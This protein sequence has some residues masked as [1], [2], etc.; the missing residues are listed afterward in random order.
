M[1]FKSLLFH[2][3]K[4][5]V[6][7]FFWKKNVLA[8]I[9]TLL[10]GLYFLA[11][12]LS[13]GLFSKPLI[14][15]LAPD[16][17]PTR[18]FLKYLF[19]YHLLDF[20]MRFKVQEIAILNPEPYRTLP[21][22]TKRL[23]SFPMITSHFSF[24]NVLAIIIFLPFT[25]TTIWAEQ[26]ILN[27]L[28]WIVL[29]LSLVLTSNYLSVTFKLFLRKYQIWGYVLYFIVLGFVV[30]EFMHITN[31][32][33]AYAWGFLKA[34][35]YPFIIL[36]PMLGAILAFRLG[37]QF[38]IKNRYDGVSSKKN[39]KI[40][41]YSFLENY[42]N[43]GHFLMLELKFIFRNKKVKAM[44]ISSLIFIGV[45]L[46]F[47]SNYNVN[48]FKNV[49]SGI[50]IISMFPTNYSQI[51]FAGMSSH[52]DGFITSLINIKTWLRAKYLLSVIA[53]TLSL[54]LSMFYG[55]ID[56]HIPL[57]NIALYLFVIGVIIPFLMY[58]S[59]FNY[60]PF[61]VTEKKSFDFKSL[62]WKS[63]IPL[64]LLIGFPYCIYGICY[65]FGNVIFVYYI[66]GG[67][68]LISLAFL[69]YWLKQIALKYHDQKHKL[70]EGFRRG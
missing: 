16:Q 25:I 20:L 31:V 51:I 59:L 12:A 41:S 67:I 53:C 66:L 50:F 14:T 7:T 64:F 15:E 2:F 44:V 28:L 29:F 8:I 5:K 17:E 1:I 63:F 39:T 34:I 60:K 32:S 33:D 6:R 13:I 69:P 36:F 38:L 45:G 58:L 55:F 22:N 43:I 37:V 40:V 24:F 52:F 3:Y 68:G 26:G 47:Y 35:Q 10:G 49:F 42:G 65:L 54:A 70:A 18:I 19:F 11:L 56:F 48:S 27:G 9:F 21:I 46:N 4:Q 62:D 61:N 23:Y 30:L 57:F